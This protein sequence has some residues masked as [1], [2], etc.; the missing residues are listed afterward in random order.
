MKDGIRS[1]NHIL[2]VIRRMGMGMGRRL[3]K[4]KISGL[5]L[6]ARRVRG[7]LGIRRRPRK[8]IHSGSSG[9]ES[10]ELGEEALDAG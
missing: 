10:I 3:G 4:G 2:M 6:I 9:I 7:G 5:G 8:R 1:P